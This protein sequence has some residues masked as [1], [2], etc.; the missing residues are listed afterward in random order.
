VN[1][2]S[3]CSWEGPISTGSTQSVTQIGPFATTSKKS[4]SMSA[5]SGISRMPYDTGT[6]KYRT[7][8]TFEIF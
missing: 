1:K 6:S 3:S 2:P 4:K 7:Y 8:F 5:L